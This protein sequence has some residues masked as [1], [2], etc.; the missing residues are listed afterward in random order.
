MFGK[1]LSAIA[2]SQVAQHVRGVDGT[3]GAVIGVVTTSVLRRLGPVGLIAAA[4]GGYALKKHFD[5]REAEKAPIKPTT[6][7]AP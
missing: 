4:V 5:K 7:T 1:V 2:G 6:T 3:S